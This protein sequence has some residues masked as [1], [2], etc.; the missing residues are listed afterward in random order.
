DSPDTAFLFP[1]EEGKPEDP[2]HR[3]LC[4]KC[5]T[6]NPMNADECS[7]CLTD[8]HLMDV[9]VYQKTVQRKNYNAIVKDCPRC[10]SHN[11]L[12]I[13]GARSST[14]SAVSVSQFYTS[15]YSGDHNEKRSL[16]FSDS[17]QDASHRSGFFTG[18]TYRFN[19]RAAVQQ[20]FDST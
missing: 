20:F 15:P 17:V 16:A 13:I 8:E 6:V 14:L 5:M 18:R 12:T 7:A 2:G 9:H 3:K 11:S 1:V 10:G 19:F 4:T